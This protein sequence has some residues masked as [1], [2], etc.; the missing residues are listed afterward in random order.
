M[1]LI[2]MIVGQMLA[3]VPVG[4][5]EAVIF[6]GIAIAAVIFTALMFPSV[7]EPACY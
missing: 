3:G 6:S 1:A 2:A 4:S 7:Q 5:G